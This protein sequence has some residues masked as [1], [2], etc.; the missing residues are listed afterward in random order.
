MSPVIKVMIDTNV[1][2]SAMY[3]THGTPFEAF[4]K[5]SRTPYR[6]VICDQIIQELCDNFKRKFPKKYPAIE[7][8]LEIAQYDVVS[9]TDE[10]EIAHDEISISHANDRPIIRAA[11]KANVDIFITGDERVCVSGITNPKIM[12]ARQFV[13]MGEFNN[14]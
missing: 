8:F 7:K 12:K 11:R 13:D 14:L 6:L 3:K 9:L 5:A 10:D 1:L 4:A 2:F